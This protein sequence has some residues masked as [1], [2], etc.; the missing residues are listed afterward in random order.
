[1]SDVQ[2]APHKVKKYDILRPH[3]GPEYKVVIES[4]PR[5]VRVVLMARPWPIPPA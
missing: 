2:E 3:S 1:M 4:S 5:R